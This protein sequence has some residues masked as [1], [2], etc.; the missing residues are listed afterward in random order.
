[1]SIFAEPRGELEG[2]EAFREAFLVAVL[3]LVIDQQDDLGKQ[4]T[5]CFHYNLS[6]R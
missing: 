3:T 5:N 6:P 1:M 4:L 2:T